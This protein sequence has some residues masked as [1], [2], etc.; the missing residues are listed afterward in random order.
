MFCIQCGQE[1]KGGTRFCTKCG[2]VQ[3]PEVAQAQSAPAA[4]YD[5]AT[6]IEAPA[7]MQLQVPSPEAPVP[8]PAVAAKR[9]SKAPIIVGIVVAII[10]IVVAVLAVIFFV[11]PKDTGMT[12]QSASNGVQQSGAVSEGS[13]SSSSVPA[14]L[15]FKGITSVY[16]SSTLPTDSLNSRDY[17]AACLIDGNVET[18]WCEY[19]SGVGLNEYVTFAGPSEQT[20]HGFKIRIG[21]QASSDLY[22]ANARPSSL[23]VDVDGV[24]QQNVRLQDKGLDW[25]TVTFSQPITGTEITLRIASAFT[26]SKYEDCCI[27]EVEFF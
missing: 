20:F 2:A 26:G 15:G 6:H 19:V 12:S 16:A 27:A 14:D 7:S 22:D 8:V 23:D 18:C 10:V 21:H 25:Q 1:L 3:V 5:A 9:K 4:E 13:T 17:S 24:F 11:L